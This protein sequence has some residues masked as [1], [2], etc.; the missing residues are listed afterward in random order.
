[1]PRRQECL[2]VSRACRPDIRVA[3]P[4]PDLLNP[5]VVDRA[6]GSREI[7]LN[8]LV[9]QVALV[10]DGLHERDLLSRQR[11]GPAPFRHLEAPVAAISI[12]RPSTDSRRVFQATSKPAVSITCRAN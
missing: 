7:C 12:V 1:W 5:G 9:V 10:N 11:I 8:G 3:L 6:T 2:K 4:S